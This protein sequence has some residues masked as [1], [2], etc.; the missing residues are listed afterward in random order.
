MPAGTNR[1]TGSIDQ[2]EETELRHLR[3]ALHLCHLL[4]RRPKRK[5]TRLLSSRHALAAR[6]PALDAGGRRPGAGPPRAAAADRATS[7]ASHGAGNDA[8]A[9]EA[10]GT[11]PPGPGHLCH[12]GERGVPDPEDP[13]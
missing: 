10:G 11:E 6:Q 8:A 2:A 3:S 12:R 4:L 9:A 5:P 13:G 7:A 1:G